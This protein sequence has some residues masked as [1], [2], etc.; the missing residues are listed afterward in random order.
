MNPPNG[1]T[2]LPNGHWVITGDTH[3]SAWSIQKG[4]II[5]DP[6]VFHFLK[7]Y[8]DGAKVVF[9]IG[10][11]IGDHTRRYIDWGFTV[12][13]VEPN[14]LAFACLTHNCPEAIAINAAASDVEGEALRFMRLENA[15]ASR[16]HPDGDIVV[17]SVVLDRENLPA[18][19]FI[20]IDAEGFEVRVLRGLRET[21]R[22]HKPI[23]F[24]EINK[25]ALAGNGHTPDD[26]MAFFEQLGY[27]NNLIYPSG[28]RHG[29]E[30]YDVLFFPL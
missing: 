17:Y 24:C 13:A 19:D 3:L 30:Q 27:S 9:D 21:I 11:C 23:V 12:V 8:L 18:P 14:P 15:G 29:D 10:G 25:G 2:V 7:P 28:A 22:T 20:K 6:H 4:N 26:I 1:V 5:T 16:V